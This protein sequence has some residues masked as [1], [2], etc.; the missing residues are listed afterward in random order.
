MFFFLSLSVSFA[1]CSSSTIISAAQFESDFICFA[2][3]MAFL[4]FYFPFLR[5]TISFWIWNA[6]NYI[7]W[8]F[9]RRREINSSNNI[10]RRWRKQ[11]KTDEDTK[12]KQFT[13]NRERETEM[14]FFSCSRYSFNMKWDRPMNGIDLMCNMFSFSTRINSFKNIFTAHFNTQMICCYWHNSRKRQTKSNCKLNPFKNASGSPEK[15]NEDSA[16]SFTV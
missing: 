3:P 11:C 4:S 12:H 15:F 14:F 6:P 7:Y 13:N 8:L 2:C 9:V 1:C 10:R 16:T 5:F